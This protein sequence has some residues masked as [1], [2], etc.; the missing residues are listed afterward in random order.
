MRAPGVSFTIED[1]GDHLYVHGRLLASVQD[2]LQH[3]R[4]L[5]AELGNM[6]R[7]G[8]PV[9]VFVDLR[10][11]LTQSAEVA[12]I[13]K[14]RTKT[15]Y[16]PGDRVAI[17]AASSILKLQLKRIHADQDFGVFVAEGAAREFIGRAVVTDAA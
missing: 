7:S 4:D 6:R 15:I 10:D 14:Q 16:R 5:S 11:C 1:R 12:E 9:R 17:L 2:A 8:R 13:I 3:F